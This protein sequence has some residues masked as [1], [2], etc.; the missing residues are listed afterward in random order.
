MDAVL[1]AIGVEWSILQHKHLA[2]PVVDV[3]T[4]RNIWPFDRMLQHG[5]VMEQPDVLCAAFGSLWA[6]RLRALHCSSRYLD[7]KKRAPIDYGSPAAYLEAK[8]WTR[9]AGTNDGKSTWTKESRTISLDAKEPDMKAW[10]RIATA[11][12]ADV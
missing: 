5:A 12:P 6:E 1:A 8:G 9:V 4:A 3:K 10:R 2:A 11:A 7:P